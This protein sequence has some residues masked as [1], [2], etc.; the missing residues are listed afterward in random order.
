MNEL[1]FDTYR[2]QWAFLWD[3]YWGG[4]RYRFP[5]PTALS[6]A[7]VRA[8]QTTRVT[9]AGQP[10]IEERAVVSYL[11]PHPAEDDRS[12]AQR[13]AL[14]TY[15]N[16]VQP[17][18]DAYAEAA[19][20]GVSRDVGA[21]ESLLDDVNQRGSSWGEFVEE[22]AR[23]AAVYGIVAAVVDAPEERDD[24]RSRADERDA[25]MRP[26]A[27]IVHPTA[28]A[29]ID[30]DERGRVTEFAY[31][32]EA[33]ADP[34][35]RGRDVVRLRVYARDGWSVR[36]GSV[37]AG[38]GLEAHRGAFAVDHDEAGNARRG[39]LPGVLRG[40]L[41]VVFCAYKRDTAGRRPMGM[42]LVADT[43]TT[44]RL[45]YN[46]LSWVSEIHR[47]AGFPFLALPLR[48]TG[49]QMDPATRVAVGPSRALPYDS[50]AGLPTYVQPSSESP[51]ELR[52][53]CVFLFQ[54]ALRTAGLEMA[55]DASA[56]V[57]SGEALRIRSRDFESRCKRFAR[58]L[59]RFEEGTLRLFAAYAGTPSE[60]IRVTYAQ[61]FTLPDPAVD[62]ANA[63]KLL[64]EVPVE[65]GAQ[66][67]VA[68]VEQALRAVLA[69][70]DERF[71]E[72]MAEVR[73]LF[74]RDAAALAQPDPAPMG[75]A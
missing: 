41:P 39:P 36:V 47:H 75:D 59:Q 66:A 24:V 43:A 8:G 20:S 56:Q 62:L 73:G 25:G 31:V 19:T 57:Q 48:S 50:G 65:I 22:V 13:I 7:S 63:L 30:T 72:V 21:L 6:S 4:E 38:A 27:T 42:S 52:E 68:A 61:R 33:Y 74:E 51:R 40:E 64:V 1:T 11:V 3:S 69:L 15:L 44:A 10:I 18:V 45:I 23:W 34:E 32:E 14:A 46:C 35:T 16:L 49:G 55:A 70:P 28:W 26:Y 67:K 60:R 5:T 2:A 53:H 17:V 71:T 9:E 37:A 29:W 54:A 12:F 58:N